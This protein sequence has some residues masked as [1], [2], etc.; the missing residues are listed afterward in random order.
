MQKAKMRMRAQYTPI[1][2][3]K[4]TPKWQEYELLDSG[5]NRKL[6]RFGNVTLVRPEAQAK[7]SGRLPM[8]RWEEA[9]GEFVKT[10]SGENGEWRFRAAVPQHWEMSRGQ[11]RFWVQPAPSGHVGVFPDQVSHWDWIMESIGRRRVRMLSLFG[12]TGLATLAASAT[13]AEVTHVDASRQAVG[14]ARENQALSGLSDRPVRW[15]VEDALTFVRREARRGNR[16]EAMM[17]DPPRFGRGPKGEIWKLEESLPELLRACGEVL[18]KSAVFV[19]LNVYVTLVTQGRVEHEAQRMAKWV[20]EMVPE[21]KI[22]AGE[23]GL[24]DRGG[25]RISASV[26]ARG[27]AS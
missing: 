9:D 22:T 13:G 24:E 3:Q 5:G 21:M 8:K 1:A 4:L 11:L 20:G 27:V 7:W 23:L 10:K 17:I 6:E 18:S 26:Y 19:V 2:L 12:H 25:R 15:I 14:W 16:Y